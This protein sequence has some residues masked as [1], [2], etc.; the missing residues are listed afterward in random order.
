MPR[1]GTKSGTFALIAL[2][3]SCI[4]PAA[5]ASW[6]AYG[7]LLSSASNAPQV[8]FPAAVSDGA[9]G[10][11]VTWLDTSE[12]VVVQ[13]VQAD[14]ALASGWPAGGMIVAPATNDP[15]GVVADGAGGALILWVG[16]ASNPGNGVGVVRMQRIDADGAVHA[17]WPIGGRMINNDLLNYAPRVFAVE[18]D[19]ENGAYI[20]WSRF[21]GG[22]GEALR[23][24][25]VTVD[26][27]FAPGWQVQGVTL[28]YNPRGLSLAVDPTGGVVVASFVGSSGL[29][30]RVGPDAV[31]T[32]STTVTVSPGTIPPGA[33]PDG[34]GGVFANWWTSPGTAQHY[35]PAGL[36]T[37][38]PRPSIAMAA[39]CVADGGGGVWVAG[40][41]RS[42][43]FV[44]THLAA[45]ATVAPGW[46]A[47]GS[48]LGNHTYYDFRVARAG[49][50]VLVCWV[51]P[52]VSQ[53]QIVAARITPAGISAGGPLK[54]VLS[55]PD[56]LGSPAL[57]TDG[58]GG[59]FAAWQGQTGIRVNRLHPDATADV[60]PSTGPTA[61]AIRGSVPNPA[62]ETVV[63]SY[64]LASS[65]PAELSLLDLSGRVRV[66][67][68][69]NGSSG[70]SIRIRLDGLPAGMYWARLRQDHQ[71]A[72]A[73]LVV[74][75]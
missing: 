12:G 72:G 56:V 39:R 10:V 70:G 33:E 42:A 8:T 23:L 11:F 54:Q 52:V 62:R 5:H 75:R 53:E 4:A 57:V 16:P 58:T 32:L 64:S 55:D 67:Q 48:L 25:R 3:V 7:L 29:I 34:S 63:F 26:G 14:G 13:H 47:S 40:L 61:L 74:I 44:M 31:T 21:E 36:E 30:A 37:W 59:G 22:N 45:D 41:D 18:P 69:L 24:T 51:D 17:G 27:A 6:P 49:S 1:H 9:G 28:G 19:G 43:R 20:G 66:T 71:I 68:T 38:L 50:D 15:P 65:A 2:I 60:A 46:T 73:K 35:T